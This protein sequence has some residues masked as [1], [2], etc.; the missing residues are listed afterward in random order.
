MANLYHVFILRNPAVTRDEVETVLNEAPDWFRY[1]DTCY[2][3]ETVK[4][5]RYWKEKLKPLVLPDGYI[6]ICKLD[7][8]HFQGWMTPAFW[9]WYESKATMAQ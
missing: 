3:L 6:F 5:P 9:K 2:V 4:A 1:Y 7:E 8:S